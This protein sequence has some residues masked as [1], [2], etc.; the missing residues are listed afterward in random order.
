LEHNLLI[1]WEESAGAGLASSPAEEVMTRE[2]W[3]ALLFAL[4]LLVLSLVQ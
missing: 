4:I 3:Q 2:N 1:P